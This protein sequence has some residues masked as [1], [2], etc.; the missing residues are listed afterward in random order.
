MPPRKSS[1]KKT[2]AEIAAELKAAEA[3]LKR[4]QKEE[5]AA[6][7]ET[8]KAE[9]QKIKDK[10]NAVSARARKQQEADRN[11]ANIIVGALINTHIEHPRGIATGMSDIL[12]ELIDRLSIREADREHLI[13][14]EVLPSDAST[15]PHFT[16]R[17]EAHNSVGQHDIGEGRTPHHPSA[18]AP[19]LGEPT[20][21]GHGAHDRGLDTDHTSRPDFSSANQR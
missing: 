6:L 1:T 20:P 12:R 9:H 14:M 7:K 10:L 8:Q 2:P 21:S 3:E 5:L 4:K 17:D 11:R 15:T 16:D 19:A 13:K 18:T